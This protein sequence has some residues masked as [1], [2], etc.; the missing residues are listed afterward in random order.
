MKLSKSMREYQIQY[1]VSALCLIIAGKV[2]EKICFVYNNCRLSK[3]EN[4]DNPNLVMSCQLFNY[5][6]VLH[7][8]FAAQPEAKTWLDTIGCF[9]Q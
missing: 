8:D 3:R 5:V 4:N 6:Y 1:K 7:G 9:G 2:N